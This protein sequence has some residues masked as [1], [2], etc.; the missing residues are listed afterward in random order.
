MSEESEVKA[1]ELGWVPKEEFRGD[2]EKW[3][4]ADT[5]VKR[6]EELMPL[7]KAN[8][9][10]QAE[11]I[12]QLETEI[13]STKEALKDATEA[14][15]ALKET[16]SKAAI[17]EVKAQVKSIKEK[18]VEAKKEGDVEAEVELQEKLD[19]AKEAVR[20]AE[21]PVIAKT[22]AATDTQPDYTTNPEWVAWTKDNPW[23]GQDKRKT[24]LALGI[25]Q[26]LREQGVKLQGRA[27]FD[28]VTEEV[29]ETLGL[30]K[31]SPT[32]SKV[33]GDARGSGAGGGSGKSYADLPAEAKQICERQAQRLVGTN[34]AF[35]TVAEWRA[36]Y[37]SEYFKE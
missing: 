8:N 6:G 15:N 7:L 9:K 35:K 1:R 33:E 4:D 26:E 17:A 37:A 31:K 11:K 20:Q 3:I 18:L 10:R 2:P 28:K 13:R 30:T 27:F 29:N 19:E 32:T 25:A 16:T 36:H 21:K 14:I 34:R 12:S 23:F 22:A 24:S 5:F